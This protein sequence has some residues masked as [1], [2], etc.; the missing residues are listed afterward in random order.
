ML[1][2]YFWGEKMPSMLLMAMGT[3]AGKIVPK[4]TKSCT[5]NCYLGMTII[6]DNNTDDDDNGG[7]WGCKQQLFL[8]I[9]LENKNTD[10]KFSTPSFIYQR[11][12][13]AS[14]T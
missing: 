7:A 5:N 9:T 12:K 1:T 8:K 10:K 2:G 3:S 6:V 11:S 14:S 13:K 4:L